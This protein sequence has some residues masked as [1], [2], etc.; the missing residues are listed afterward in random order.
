MQAGGGI[1]GDACEPDASGRAARHLDRPGDRQPAVGAAA[2]RLK[3][4]E[5]GLK[6][7]VADLTPEK[8]ILKEAAV[9]NC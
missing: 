5:Q 6:R 2:W 8:L 9:G 7:A 4:L 1:V 3:E